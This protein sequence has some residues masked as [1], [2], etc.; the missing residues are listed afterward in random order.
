MWSRNNHA[1]TC[2]NAISASVAAHPAKSKS[3]RRR[4]AVHAAETRRTDLIP[5]PSYAPVL[6]LRVHDGE[7]CPA[8]VSEPLYDCAPCADLAD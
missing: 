3:N 7:H 2:R 8:H 5:A 6:P 4:I 1:P